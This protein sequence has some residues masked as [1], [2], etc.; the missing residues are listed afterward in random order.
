MVGAFAKIKTMKR[1]VRDCRVGKLAFEN[2][3]CRMISGGGF[4]LSQQ[5]QWNNDEKRRSGPRA[6]LSRKTIRSTNAHRVRLCLVL[7]TGDTATWQ[8][9]VVTKGRTGKNYDGKYR[10]LA[11]GEK[12]MRRGLV[13]I[14]I[15]RRQNRGQS[16][17]LDDK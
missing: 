5:L 9:P 1:G 15:Q 3:L 14:Q 2:A 12:D 10:P 4:G 16:C 6:G 17:N 11:R 8:S 7:V 13:L